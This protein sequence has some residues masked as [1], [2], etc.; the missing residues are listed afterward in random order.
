MSVEPFY[1]ILKDGRTPL[2]VGGGVTLYTLPQDRYA[3]AVESND[4]KK[5]KRLRTIAARSR[6]VAVHSYPR[7]MHNPLRQVMIVGNA[8]S[9]H[10]CLEAFVERDW[11][12]A[13]MKRADREI[14][15]V[16][17]PTQAPA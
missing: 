16:E 17:T 5:I 9:V 7:S 12:A 3:V 2:P 15:I 11:F 13:A 8:A 14:D 6:T 1:Q 4:I 10:A